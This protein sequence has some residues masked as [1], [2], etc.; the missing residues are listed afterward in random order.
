MHP[1]FVSH[2]AAAAVDAGDTQAAGEAAGTPVSIHAKEE[3]YLGVGM[4]A[5]AAVSS[6]GAMFIACPKGALSQ[7][8]KQ[9]A[10]DGLG[11]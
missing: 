1:S 2:P 8:G 3:G 6:P 5:V 9:R 7:H 4:D 11:G 10:M